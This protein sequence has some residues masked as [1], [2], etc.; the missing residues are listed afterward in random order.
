MPRKRKSQLTTG[1]RCRYNKYKKP[2]PVN[3]STNEEIPHYYWNENIPAL[4]TFTDNHEKEPKQSV[5]ENCTSEDNAQRSENAQMLD[6]FHT[7]MD[8]KVT[9]N[10]SHQK[11]RLHNN[12]GSTVS[13]SN[14]NIYTLLTLSKWRTVLYIQ[15]L[16]IY[17]SN[18]Y[19][20]SS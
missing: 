4:F 1:K 5:C 14:I 16:Y 20:V 15:I 19:Y 10:K 17:L 11:L 6:Q 7:V 13:W 3:D 8:K 9:T 12:C 18:I 2:N